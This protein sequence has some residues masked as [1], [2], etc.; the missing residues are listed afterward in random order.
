MIDQV[1]I[2]IN[3]AASDNK[4]NEHESKILEIIARVN[5]VSKEEFNQLLSHPK[6][7]GDLNTYGE[8]QK[9]EILYMMI[10]LMK[11]DGQIFKSEITFCERIA[12]RLGYHPD[13]IAELSTGIFSN[14]SITSDRA[15]LLATAHEYLK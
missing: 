15:T 14:P 6:P 12:E 1:N 5:G 9:F 8:D 11:S 10:Q 4:V 7:I 3:L 13:V 2:L